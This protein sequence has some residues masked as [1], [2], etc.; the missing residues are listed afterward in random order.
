MALGLRVF[1]SDYAELQLRTFE[2]L[3]GMKITR[4]DRGRLTGR[5]GPLPRRRLL[6]S[7]D[8][9]APAAVVTDVF[10]RDDVEAAFAA[11][12]R[13]VPPVRAVLLR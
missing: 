1:Y 3:L 6:V 8:A 2:G 12:D 11:H 5:R 10:G 4:A 9:V 7:S 13:D